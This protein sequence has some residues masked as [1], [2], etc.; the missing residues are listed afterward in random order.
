MSCSVCGKESMFIMGLP[1]GWMWV[2]IEH[3]DSLGD[4]TTHKKHLTLCSKQCLHKYTDAL[5]HDS[6]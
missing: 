6:N 5:V 2:D 1:Y 3:N 4:F